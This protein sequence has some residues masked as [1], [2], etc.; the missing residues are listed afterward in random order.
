METTTPTVP[1]SYTTIKATRSRMEK[2]LLAIPASLI[3]LFPRA[4]GHV[5]LV[6]EQGLEEK[7]SFTAYTSRSKECRIGRM[8]AFYEKYSIRDGDEL[9]LLVRGDNRYMI[10]PEERFH[11]RIAG[12]EAQ[13]DKASSNM[14]ANAALAGIAELTVTNREEVIRSEFV[15]LAQREVLERKIRKRHAVNVE[16]KVSASL[17]EMLL[18]LYC[19]R[20]QVSGFTFLMKTGEPYF[21]VHH[22]NPMQG[23]HVKNLLVVSPN[24]H[25]Q[26][27]YARVEH[28]FDE[29]GWLRQVCF[30]G[31]AHLVFQVV[32]QL[33]ASFKKEVYSIE[34]AC[35][36]T[37]M[38][39]PRIPFQSGLYLRTRTSSARA[40]SHNLPMTRNRQVISSTPM[41]SM[42]IIFFR[43]SRSLVRRLRACPT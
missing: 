28:A 11:Q 17:R 35:L 18:G 5:F 23:D 36:G 43:R 22:I 15:R 14:D 2:G 31:D 29:M 6:D 32:D 7:T 4:S 30:N 42:P 26:F 20:C 24:V 33:P 40:T 12:F 25:A 3:H 34:G 9:V 41:P 16:E 27:T 21:E 19:G 38:L 13:L 1:F 37:G 10:L 8:R 39:N